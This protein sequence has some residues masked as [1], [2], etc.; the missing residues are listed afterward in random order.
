MFSAIRTAQAA[1]A[2][3]IDALLRRGCQH[4]YL[5]VGSNRGVQIRKLFEPWRYPSATVQPVYER[6]F[7][8]DRCRVCAIGM[9]PNPVVFRFRW[10]CCWWGTL[11]DVVGGA[12]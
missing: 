1:D 4:A 7:G 6:L 9:E 12:A 2:H 3:A 8:V 10:R 11:A 5:D